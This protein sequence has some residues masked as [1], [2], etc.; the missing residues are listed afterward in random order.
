ML[1]HQLYLV[2]LA[3]F[4]AQAAAPTTGFGATPSAFGAPAST[5]FGGS[6]TAGF[7]AGGFGATAA[8]PAT[9]FGGFGTTATSQPSTGF[10]GAT[11]AFGAAPAS[12]GLFGA[13][14]PGTTS[15]FG[16]PATSAATGFG[17]FGAPQVSAAPT[18]AG[19]GFGGLGGGA[20][21]AAK[22]ATTSLF[23][24]PATSTAAPAFGGFGAAPAA[25]T[26]GGLFGGATGGSSLFPAS[27]AATTG[28]LFGGGGAT[29]APAFG[30]STA[31]SGLFGA[32]PATT[33]GLF[34]QTGG[35]AFGAT[36]SFGTGAPA[37]TSLFGGSGMTGGA[38][39]ASTAGTGMFGGATHATATQPAMIASVNGNIYG[40][41]PL[42]QR[43]TTLPASKVQPAVLSR[44]EPAQKLPAHIPPV[45]FSPRHTQIRLRPTSTA[46]F[47]SS[48]SST[49]DLSVGRKSLLLLDGI[50]DESAFSSDDYAPRRSVKK[51]ELKP[52]GQESAQP[53]DGLNGHGVTFNSTLETA[54]ADS[55][56]RGRA[57]ADRIPGSISRETSDISFTG[58]GAPAA[59]ASRLGSSVTTSSDKNQGEYWMEPSLEELRK[60]TRSELQSV[61]NFKVGLPE[62]GSVDFLEPVDLTTVPSLSS[63]CGH[64]VVFS[65]KVCKVYPDEHNKPP[66]GQG[67]NVPAIISLERCW[68][69]DKSTREPIKFEKSNPLYAQHLKR[70][71]RQSETTF[72]DFVTDNGTWTF[73][74][75]HFSEYGL[76]DDDEEE[77][78]Q[79]SNLTGHHS[80]TAG[81]SSSPAV[82]AFVDT[83]S[84]ESPAQARMDVE[85]GRADS[86]TNSVA[87][88]V[89]SRNRPPPATQT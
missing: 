45:R 35:S 40:D 88:T 23:G 29:A 83:I 79:N 87:R 28:G 1:T 22:P 68:P 16:A 61:R 65:H 76:S 33:G 41:N 9:G 44:S 72:M 5:G 52:R 24:N 13:A 57:G 51:L 26:G 42:F 34:G 18:S 75:E 67:L 8:K 82:P 36:P 56:F 63:I 31:S 7:G 78:A 14:A 17:G 10:G 69:L 46:T 6:A 47:S 3:G 20:F 2:L 4:G 86:P 12:T 58:F 74:V 60:M 49:S 25:G 37:S 48:V 50:N 80:A 30:T 77:G 32:K 84:H 81:S 11:N 66:R 55:I 73:R 62:Y 53:K 59:V 27:S 15:A 54:A 19:L 89:H 38:F 21:G 85:M 70:L 71:K 39:G 64:I 43:D